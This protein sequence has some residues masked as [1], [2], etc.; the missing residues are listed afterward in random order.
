LGK[1]DGVPGI[2]ARTAEL[3]PNQGSFVSLKKQFRRTK[4]KSDHFKKKTVGPKLKRRYGNLFQ[5]EKMAVK[6]A[7]VAALVQNAVGEFKELLT[8]EESTE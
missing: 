7:K 8:A 2:S 6:K 4:K 5:S 3:P 1:C